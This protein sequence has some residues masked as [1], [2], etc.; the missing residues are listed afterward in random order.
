MSRTLSPYLAKRRGQARTAVRG[1]DTQSIVISAFFFAALLLMAG[2]AH[3]DDGADPF[4][5][6]SMHWKSL[7]RFQEELKQAPPKVMPVNPAPSEATAASEAAEEPAKTAETEKPAPAPLTRPINIPLLPG[8]NK[9]YDVHVT[10]TAETSSAPTVM[11]D[12]LS[13]TPVPLNSA[14]WQKAEEA[15]SRA[16][17]ST[18]NEGDDEAEPL[19]V[20]MSFLP[21]R[22][23]VPVAS[24][25]KKRPARLAAIPEKPKAKTQ[26]EAATCAAIDADKKRQLQAIQNDQKTLQALQAAIKEL[27]LNKD[28]DFLT[29]AQVDGPSQAASDPKMDTAPSLPGVRTN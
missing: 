4:A 23:V 17:T 28:L 14:N 12:P 1:A 27:G 11:P 25:E 16:H 19:N 26:A 10:S 18:H 21:D 13:P 24:A 5:F 2:Y 9:G 15:A 7:D 22:S 6:D 3:A 8:I 20:R 29:N